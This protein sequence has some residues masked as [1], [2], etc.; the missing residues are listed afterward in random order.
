MELHTN[1]RKLRDASKAQSSL[2]PEELTS[3]R[4]VDT[5]VIPKPS[6]VLNLLEDMLEAEVLTSVDQ[7]LHLPLT[8]SLLLVD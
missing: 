4:M 7:A 8:Q 3:T 1:G 6:P 2:E 5:T